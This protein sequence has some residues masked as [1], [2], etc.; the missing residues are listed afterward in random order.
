[1]KLADSWSARCN[2]VPI[3]SIVTALRKSALKKKKKK[4]VL[5]NN[6]NYY[7]SDNIKMQS[8]INVL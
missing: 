2:V 7:W 4:I 5:Y 8:T 1:M 6:P 3:V